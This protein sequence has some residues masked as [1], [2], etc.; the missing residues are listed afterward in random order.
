MGLLDQFPNLDDETF[1]EIV[2]DARLLIP[3]FARE[4]WTDHNVH[5]PGITFIE[6][7]AWLAEMQ[8]YQLNRVTEKNYR[9]FLK[10]VGI[11]PYDAKPAK[12]DIT[13][14]LENKENFDENSDTFIDKGTKVTTELDGKEIVFVTEDKV[15]LIQS[16]LKTI[17]TRSNSKIVDNTA[18]NKEDD[19]YFSAFGEKGN[20]GAT[21][22][23]GFDKPL[24]QKEIQITFDIF[25]EDLPA[26]E[27]D[28]AEPVFSIILSWEYLDG[29]KKWKEFTLKKD[30]TLALNR[31]GRITFDMSSDMGMSEDNYWIRCLWKDSH[32]EV[33]PLVNRIL[34]NTVP[35]VQIETV[36]DH[37]DTGLG[38]PD[39]KVEIKIKPVLTGSL[40]VIIGD[41]SDEKNVWVEQDFFESSGPEDKHYLFNPEKGE[42]NFGN[43]LNGKI[44]EKDIRFSYQTTLGQK[45]N[46]PKG[47]KWVI[48]KTGFEN[49]TG[50]NYKQATGGQDAESIEQAK[51]RAKKDFRDFYRAVTSGDYE[52]LALST[53]GL[54]VSRAKA[55]P[56]YHPEYPCI[57]IP[58]STTVI[59]VPYARDDE[60]KPVP[61][62]SFLQTVSSFLDTRRLITADLHVIGPEYVKIAVTCNVR[63]KKKN[64]PTEVTKRIQNELNKFLDPLKGGP[65]GKGW[66]FGRAVYKSEIYQIIN[67][68]EGLDYASGVS[69]STE[70]DIGQDKKVGDIIKI[71]PIALVV[72]GEHKIVIIE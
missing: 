25:D 49:I 72:S 50:G 66:P 48:I 5:D 60:N 26:L 35:A 32:Y 44:P 13:F 20:I 8:M 65:D 19:I 68:I 70:S 3:Q 67:N 17:I 59:V 24:P 15:N 18:A 62:S 11:S 30:T 43:G 63:I 23:L 28:D 38:F 40:K 9:K 46:V 6:L 55:I 61:G 71:S 52:Q 39:Q 42:I 31:S 54:R 21:L 51:S 22:E 1:E 57:G 16:N 69:L 53:P 64:S 10:L 29:D 41:S 56:N 7:F 36:N 14:N 12:V 34:V 37:Q 47:Q 2:K 45:G 27:I 58:D 33:A 4:S